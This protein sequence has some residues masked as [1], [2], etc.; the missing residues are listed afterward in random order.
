MSGTIANAKTIPVSGLFEENEDDTRPPRCVQGEATMSQAAAGN[1]VREGVGRRPDKA[2]L[3]RLP[4]R[5]GAV[6][7]YS[8]GR[9]FVS[10]YLTTTITS[11]R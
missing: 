4:G 1:T 11:R 8:G 9:V 2:R 7:R 5:L 3:Q 6:C 10:K